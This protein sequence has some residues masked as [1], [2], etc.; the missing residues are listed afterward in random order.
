VCPI[1]DHEGSVVHA[2]SAFGETKVIPKNKTEKR[3]TEVKK[4]NTDFLIKLA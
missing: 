3:K 1:T 4:V 2:A